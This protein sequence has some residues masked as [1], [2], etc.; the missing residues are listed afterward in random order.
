MQDIGYPSYR[1]AKKSNKM[2]WKPRDYQE[3]GTET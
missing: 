1:S 3:P 2:E